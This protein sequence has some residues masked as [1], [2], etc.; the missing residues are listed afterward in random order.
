MKYALVIFALL[1]TATAVE[2][3]PRRRGKT[4][5]KTTRKSTAGQQAAAA[6]ANALA[7]ICKPTITCKVGK[8]EGVV[9]PLKNRPNI[10]NAGK[11]NCRYEVDRSGKQWIETT[12]AQCKDVPVRQCSTVHSIMRV[13]TASVA[14]MTGTPR[15]GKCLV[16]PRVSLQQ[17]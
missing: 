8:K 11:I 1:F 3:A 15:D 6:A 12:K 17:K 16:M 13:R 2:A 14:Y 10:N 9:L 4:T 5:K 7:N